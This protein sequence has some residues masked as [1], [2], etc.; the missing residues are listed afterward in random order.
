MS[1]FILVPLHIVLAS[2]IT[3][4]LTTIFLLGHPEFPGVVGM[5]RPHMAVQV[6]HFGSA[7]A[8]DVAFTGFRVVI[9]VF[10]VEHGRGQLRR[11]DGEG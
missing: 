9:D 7:G 11:V 1:L 10:A 2:Q 5:V 6:F 8:A 3:T 4:H